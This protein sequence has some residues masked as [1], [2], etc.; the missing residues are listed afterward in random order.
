L[1]PIGELG[2][3]PL[4]RVGLV[5]PGCLL[6]L[7]VDKEGRRS[8]RF[9]ALLKLTVKRVERFL[10]TA[11]MRL[12]R[13]GEGLEPLGDLFEALFARGAGHPWIHVGIFVGF[14]RNR[15]N[16][17]LRSAANRLAGYRIANFLKIFEVTMGV[18]GLTLCG[19]A[20]Y[21]RDVVEPLDIAF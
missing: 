13:F 14:P 2:I 16:E 15:S 9:D 21:R 19:R 1:R 11:G 20:E 18:A 7:V 8:S 5:L 3:V 10:E 12:L 6:S 17:I 4:N